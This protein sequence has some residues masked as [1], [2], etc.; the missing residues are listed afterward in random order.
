MYGSFR[1]AHTLN[2]NIYCLYLFNF[3]EEQS[4]HFLYNIRWR[5]FHFSTTLYKFKSYLLNQAFPIAQ[6]L[7]FTIS[8]MRFIS[9]CIDFDIYNF[10]YEVHF[11]LNDYRYY[12]LSL[13]RLWKFILLYFNYWTNTRSSQD[14]AIMT[15]L[16]RGFSSALPLHGPCSGLEE[17]VCNDF[18]SVYIV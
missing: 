14:I 11:S 6:I 10:N 8:T 13:P 1:K 15:I 9:R 18:N 17:T 2:K 3:F 16:V 4:V 12:V 7:I 5:T